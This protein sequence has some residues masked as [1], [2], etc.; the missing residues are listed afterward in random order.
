MPK[1]YLKMSCDANASK[2]ARTQQV[3]EEQNLRSQY[4]GC[5]D[6]KSQPMPL[7]NQI[8]LDDTKNIARIANAVQVTICLLVSTISIH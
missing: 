6:E 7:N 2:L 1:V 3:I 5:M 4:I 8:Y